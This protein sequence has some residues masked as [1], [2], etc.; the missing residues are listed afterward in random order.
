MSARGKPCPYPVDPSWQNFCSLYREA[1]TAD[2]VVTAVEKSH[3]MMAALYFGISAVEAFLNGQMRKHL[4]DTQSPEEVLQA[5]RQTRFRKKLKEWPTEITKQPLL[6]P[7]DA[8]ELISLCNDIRGD[9]THP[10]VPNHEIYEDLLEIGPA[11]VV[12]AV[13]KYIVAFHQAQGTTYPYWVF[14]WNY[15]NPRTD[16]YEIIVLN[17]QQF[18]HS[19]AS[20]GFRVA[21]QWPDYDEWTRRYMGS[22]DGYA[23]IR[24]ALL[25]MERC[26]PKYVR[27]PHQPKLCR[28]WWTT[29]HHKTCGHASREAIAA[30][31]RLDGMVAAPPAPPPGLLTRMGTLLRALRRSID[32]G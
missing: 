18:C 2:E 24:T 14:G 23:A 7:A 32:R 8:L 26:E 16:A 22:L 5:L 30:A 1:C 29:E 25:G 4:R 10:K 27:F 13:A 11:D 21:M 19:L 17:E 20:L 9:L 6:V 12:D 28:R 15:L 3:H 31:R